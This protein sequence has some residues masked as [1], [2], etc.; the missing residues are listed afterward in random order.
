MA[1]YTEVYELHN[2]SEFRNKVIIACV[3]AALTISEEDSGTPNNDNRLLWAASCLGSPS[4]KANE[5]FN[6][7]I[8][9]NKDL[10]IGD[11]GTPGTILGATDAQIQAQVDANV[12][13][14]ATG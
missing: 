1:T 4:S 11:S 3:D 6:V 5:M 14:F 8:V 10:D 13:L 9:A 2:N 12:N 7:V